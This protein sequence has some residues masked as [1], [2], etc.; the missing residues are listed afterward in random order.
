MSCV[1]ELVFA[2]YTRIFHRENQIAAVRLVGAA[3][4][5]ANAIPGYRDELLNN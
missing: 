5:A 2:V 4:A 3:E 1:L